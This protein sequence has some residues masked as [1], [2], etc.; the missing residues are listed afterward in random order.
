MHQVNFSGILETDGDRWD[1]MKMSKKNE[2]DY[3]YLIWK[4]EKN[5][6]R[7]IVGQLAK[8]GEYEFRYYDKE[9]REAIKEGFEP[10]FLL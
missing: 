7:Y 9:I 5:G 1:G 6:K 4:A 2:K 8:N 3:L 10:F